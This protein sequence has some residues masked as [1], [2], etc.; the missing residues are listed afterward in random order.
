MRSCFPK[1][2]ILL[3]QFRVVKE[4][5][6]AIMD[7]GADLSTW[8]KDRLCTLAQLLVYAP[9]ELVYVTNVRGIVEI[10]GTEAH[11][12]VTYFR[13]T[14]DSCHDMWSTYKRE[15]V[16]TF[17]ANESRRLDSTWREIQLRIGSGGDQNGMTLDETVVSIQFFQAMVE[18]SYMTKLRQSRSS[19]I[20][21][22]A[23]PTSTSEL[24]Y[25]DEMKLLASTISSHACQLIHPQ[26]MHAIGRGQYRFCEPS[27]GTFFV[28]AVAPNDAFC[29]EPGKEFCVE[30]KLGWQCSCAFMVNHHLPCR[31]IFYI[32]CIIRCNSVIPIETLEHRWV[33][34][35]VCAFFDSGSLTSD[36]LRVQV[37]GPSVSDESADS[38]MDDE[39]RNTIVVSPGSWEKFVSAMDIGKRIGLQ[40]MQLNDVEFSAAVRYY[41]L[42]EKSIERR[43]FPQAT[44]IASTA[45][46]VTSGRQAASTP[47]NRGGR[48]PTHH[49][50]SAPASRVSSTPTANSSTLT[51]AAGIGLTPPPAQSGNTSEVSAANPGR[52]PTIRSRD[53]ELP[54]LDS[55]NPPVIDL[56]EDSDTDD[57]EEEEEGSNHDDSDAG[58]SLGE[59]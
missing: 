51:T 18:R 58:D 7:R 41:Q 21:R 42:V 16:T 23:G 9:T 50:G 2:R 6:D 59:D 24:Q 40:V 48:P 36:S 56:Q 13:K 32:R 55:L 14:W 52:E 34:R 28:S 37:Q 10:L 31:H 27:R 5:H 25:D 20:I 35:E 4:L 19:I 17:G 12:F 45:A 3:S 22:P 1:A 26:Y 43:E 33:L 8:H 39:N 57:N 46:A 15:N 38:S 11:P 30:E 49:S 54:S 53:G 47:V 44:R 29:D